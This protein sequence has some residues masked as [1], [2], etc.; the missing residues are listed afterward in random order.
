MPHNFKDED[1]VVSDESEESEVV[2][3]S[4]RALR[5]RLQPPENEAESQETPTKKV[6]LDDNRLQKL[7]KIILEEAWKDFFEEKQLQLRSIPDEL[8]EEWNK[9]CHR[10][11]GRNIIRGKLQCPIENCPKG[12]TCLG[13]IRYHY[14]RCNLESLKPEATCKLCGYKETLSKRLLPHFVEHHFDQMPPVPAECQVIIGSIKEK[15]EARN[16]PRDSM[17]REPRKS[18]NYSIFFR[19]SFE[20][21]LNFR[22]RVQRNNLF[23]D[24][25]PLKKHWTPLSNND[26]F[27]PQADHCRLKFKTNTNNTWQTIPLFKSVIHD[28]PGQHKTFFVGSPVVSSAWAPVPVSEKSSYEQILALSTSSNYDATH[29]Y[30]DEETEFS[31]VQFWNMGQL[32]KDFTR[33]LPKLEFSIGMFCGVV[34]SME[35]APYASTWM[36]PT[37]KVHSHSLPRLGLLALAC[38]DGSVRI[39][40]IPQPSA[41]KFDRRKHHRLCFELKPCIELDPPGVGPA[42]SG[43][44]SICRCVS[45]SSAKGMTLI[46]AGYGNGIVCVWDILTQSPF[47]VLNES[48][49]ELKIVSPK[50]SWFAHGS[51]VNAICFNPDAEENNVSL[52]TAGALDREVIRW[53]L[54]DLSHCERLLKKSHVTD[55]S[56]SYTWREQ[57]VFLAFDEAFTNTQYSNAT[58]AL[59]LVDSRSNHSI[60]RHFATV[61]SISFSDWLSSEVSCDS[62]GA[63]TLFLRYIGKDFKLKERQ[64]HTFPLYRLALVELDTNANEQ[65]LSGSSSEKENESILNLHTFE[66]ITGKKGVQFVDVTSLDAGKIAKEELSGVNEKFTQRQM[67]PSYYP[68][69]SVNQV[70]WNPNYSCYN[71]VFTGCQNGLCRISCISFPQVLNIERENVLEDERMDE[72]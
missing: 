45:W 8:L 12:F 61:N 27:L 70:K 37:S 71:W 47:L 69:V 54:D 20:S 52:I 24:L 48:G 2:P 21:Y 6:D 49:P 25:L 51:A 65:T 29:A 55:M 1:Y 43:Q 42:S 38:G 62:D 46:A 63:V 40:S 72:S 9:K 15:I 66:G 31:V 53:N 16:V 36:S 10:K 14:Q 57:F 33:D 7:K 50:F 11:K 35:W 32:S 5:S 67:H 28:D 39:V 30:S 19:E 22:K 41:L 4:N 59:P 58:Y 60:S 68:L 44:L 34:W 26:F 17:P 13:G 64:C 23:P 56:W 18:I 3:V